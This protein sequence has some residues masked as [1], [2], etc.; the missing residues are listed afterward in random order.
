[1]G[2]S[3]LQRRE[4]FILINMVVYSVDVEYEGIRPSDNYKAHTLW[5]TIEGARKALKS[6]RDEILRKPGWSENSIE[7]D[8]DDHFFAYENG[9]FYESYEI[10]ITEEKV[11]E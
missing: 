8:E 7:T 2:G 11:Y 10:T 9:D 6:E 1:M 5:S 4:A 3:K